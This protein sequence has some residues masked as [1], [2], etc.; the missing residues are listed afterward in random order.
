MSDPTVK[1]IVH[2]VEETKTYGQKGFRKR[3]VVLEQDNVHEDMD[4]FERLSIE[5]GT[6]GGVAS[7]PPL[8]R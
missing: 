6:P 3:L 7:Y 2:V 5:C 4:A 8:P 1:G